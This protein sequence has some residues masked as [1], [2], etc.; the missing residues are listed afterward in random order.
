MKKKLKKISLS[1]VSEKLSDS[2]L[3]HIIG[4]GYDQCNHGIGSCYGDCI[5][6]EGGIIMPGR[7]KQ[8]NLHDCVCSSIY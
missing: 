3:K 1:N 2:Q 8:M 7:C 5:A 6:I 4:G